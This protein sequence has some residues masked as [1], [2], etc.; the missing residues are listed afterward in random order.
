MNWLKKWLVGKVIR[1]LLKEVLMLTF[2]SGY[3][4]YIVAIVVAVVTGVYQLNYIDLTTYQTVLGWLG[5]AGLATL[6]AGIGSK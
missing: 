2:L 6:R 3:R 5:A 4:T 1:Q